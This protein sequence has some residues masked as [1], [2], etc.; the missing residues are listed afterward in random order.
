MD[1]SDSTGE[2]DFP[3]SDT[4][5]VPAEPKSKTFS[6]AQRACLKSF[7]SNGM[8][9]VGKRYSSLIEQAANDTHL[10]VDQVK[11]SSHSPLC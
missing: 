5:D 11:V 10:A 8:V 3:Q 4:E 9:G 1:E 7:F 2:S 6:V